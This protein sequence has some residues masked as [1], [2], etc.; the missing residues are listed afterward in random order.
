MTE[1]NKPKWYQ[2]HK[3]DETKFFGYGFAPGNYF[4]TCA[5]CGEQFGPA[6]KRSITCLDCAEK[7][8]DQSNKGA[9]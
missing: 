8:I 1:H 9:Q 6:D 2:N 3:L 7:F 4:C 5:T